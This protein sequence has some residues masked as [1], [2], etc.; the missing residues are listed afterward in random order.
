MNYGLR[1]RELATSPDLL[2]RAVKQVQVLGVVNESLLIKL[3]FLTSISRLLNKPLH[4]LV[5]GPSSGWQELRHRYDTA[6]G[7]SGRRKA[8]HDLEP[9]VACLRR[10]ATIAHGP[11]G[12]RGHANSAGS[13]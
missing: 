10:G 13:K 12:V 6:A 4:L 3:V 1:S 11:R 5:R 8:P 9:V 7:S 2:D